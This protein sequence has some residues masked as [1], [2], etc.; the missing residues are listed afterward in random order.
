MRGKASVN[1]PKQQYTFETWDENGNDRAVSVLGLPDESDWVLKASSWDK[2]LM[3]NV[4][5]FDWSRD[6][7][8][9]ASAS[10]Y[11]EVYLN[12]DGGAVTEDPKKFPT[13]SLWGNVVPGASR[14]RCNLL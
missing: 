9:Y 5:A 12:T 3:R 1:A 13:S 2:S 6:M 7:G 4:L 14:D 10:R 8:Y 11:V